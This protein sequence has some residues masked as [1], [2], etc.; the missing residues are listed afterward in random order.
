MGLTHSSMSRSTA[1]LLSCIIVCVALPLLTPWLR[2]Q[3]LAA[4][5]PLLLPSAIAYSPQGDLYLAETAN[6]VIRK[7]DP[8]SR[9]TTIAGTGTQG[10]DGDGGPATAALLDSPAGLALDATTLYIADTHNHAIR[11]VNL[12]TGAITTLNA[13]LNRPIA[14]ALD[15]KSHLFIAD[16]GSHQIRRIDLPTG[17]LTTV[18]GTGTQGFSGDTA[19]AT[20]ALLD[21]P[22]GLAADA[23]G[24]LYLADTHN[25]RIRRI[26]TSGVITTLA[27]NGAFGYA[28]DSGSATSASLALPQGLTIDPLGNLYLADSANHR[29]R[30][31]DA[32]IGT[33]TTLAGDGVQDFAPTS[34][35]SPRATIISP[36]GRITL[37]DTGNQRIRQIT[38][39]T[40]TTV[41]GL[42]AVTSSALTLTGPFS[43]SY[44]TGS[45]TASLA[46]GSGATGAVTFLDTFLGATTQAG[47][48]PLA[49]GAATLD[50]STLTAGEHAITASYAG[51]TSHPAA[52]SSAFPLLVTRAASATTLTLA[53]SP[54]VTGTSAGPVPIGPVPIGIAPGQPVLITAHVVSATRGVPT[55]TVIVSDGSTLLAAGNAN[56]AGDLVFSTTALAA[57]PHSLFAAYEGDLN[58]Q[59]STS[60][61]TLL[62][63]STPPTGADFTLAPSGSTTQTILSGN[64]ADF[65]F[66][67]Q[68][69]G[70][71]PG[72]IA[73]SA[74]GLPNLAT[75]SFNPGTLPPGTTS[76]T[77]TMTVA[78]QQATSQTAG[79]R[80]TSFPNVLALLLPVLG[81][82]PRRRSSTRLLLA[83]F[84]C[85]TLLAVT[86]CG[87]RIN[88]GD[89]ADSGVP[90][91]KSYPI[92]VIA[93][94]TDATG[95]TLRHTSQVTLT[96]QATK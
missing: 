70:S 2:P 88:R 53:T 3:N 24:N 71:L 79:A 60:P 8:T 62:T 80:P 51:D 89:S 69:Q 11:T 92:T 29:L 91:T 56:L 9:I 75:A 84:S 63:I 26:D 47:T 48:A 82:I 90:Q 68:V 65:T 31:I 72:P 19:Q 14:L 32:K 64:S 4:N 45:L 12:A 83:L 39:D 34:L 58:F 77:F 55:G 27:G 57:G 94:A 28:G 15:T 10:Y 67:L 86:G 7:I 17:I 1:R 44:G 46:T 96:L 43:V 81:F 74:A 21:S 33:I 95:T 54:I 59:P 42:G 76:G 85:A 20:A 25:H 87:D 41:A 30:Q 50:T 18:A 13:S 16:A 22:A 78:T 73:L 36:D 35:N 5:V 66:T 61:T 23:A 37:A 93:T 38:G 6:H 52:Q 40:L 49:A